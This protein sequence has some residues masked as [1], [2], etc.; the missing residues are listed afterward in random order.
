MLKYS[1]Q[2]AAC[3]LAAAAAS[4]A[5]LACSVS[6]S[7]SGPVPDAGSD[8]A[9]DVGHDAQEEAVEASREAQAEA[10]AAGPECTV[11]NCAGACC[12]NKCIPKDCA[13]TCD[14]GGLF[15]PYQPGFAYSNGFCVASCSDCVGAATADS[16]ACH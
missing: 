11:L 8:A 15:C 4:L 16:G 5:L 10:E 14:A 7:G 3:G 13:L 2:I 6:T 9:A 12:G 1:R